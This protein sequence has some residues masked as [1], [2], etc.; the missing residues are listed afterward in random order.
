MA[1]LKNK[2]I[3]FALIIIGVFFVIWGCNCN[4]EYFQGWEGSTPKPVA[5][6]VK[7]GDEEIDT[8]KKEL[9]T[10]FNK[11]S[12]DLCPSFTLIR[13][14]MAK[15]RDV[16]T[17]DQKR[18][19][20]VN[21]MTKEVGGKI[22]DCRSYPDH[23]QVPADIGT[24]VANTAA[25]LYKKLTQLMTTTKDALA[26][27]PAPVSTENYEDYDSDSHGMGQSTHYSGVVEYY[28]DICSP[29][30]MSIREEEAKK[31]EAQSNAKSCI[32]PTEVDNT[33]KKQLLLLRIKS[34][35]NVVEDPAWKPVI[36]KIDE[37]VKY[38]TDIKEK[39]DAG[40]L[41]PDCGGEE[42]TV[43]EFKSTA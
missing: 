1:S 16:G 28:Q 41:K 43:P 23:L 30:L 34:L 18:A 39:I 25:Y 3:Y 33:S 12:A 9:E 21:Q 35:K 14:E 19:L 13:D 2:Y 27:K 26:C 6:P 38:F 42:V 4:K 22:Y 20:A 37:A 32:A 15:Q 40:T 11:V 31:A 5:E 10:Y 8:L 36:A 17:E 29:E 7:T 24:I